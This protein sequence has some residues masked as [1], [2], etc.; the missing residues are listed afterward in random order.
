MDYIR[1]MSNTSAELKKLFRVT[2]VFSNAI[3]MKF[4][5]D[6]CKSN[7]GLGGVVVSITVEPPC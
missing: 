1:L 3:R 5:L 2:E 4:D 7:T 6:N